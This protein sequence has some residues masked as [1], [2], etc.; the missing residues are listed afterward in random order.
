MTM[1]TGPK[2]I[3]DCVQALDRL[4]RALADLHQELTR[5][6]Q[7]RSCHPLLHWRRGNGAEIQG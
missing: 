3:V 2:A 7:A 4:Q 5:P 6:L 1:A